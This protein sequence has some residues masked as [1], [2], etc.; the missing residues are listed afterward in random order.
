MWALMPGNTSLMVPGLKQTNLVSGFG[1]TGLWVSISHTC[2]KLKINSS[3]TKKHRTISQ[4]FKGWDLCIFPATGFVFS[5]GVIDTMA[6]H[7]T[8]I[9]PVPFVTL[10]ALGS[11]LWELNPWTDHFYFNILHQ[12]I[13]FL[14]LWFTPD[15]ISMSQVSK[16]T[17]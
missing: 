10:N 13:H 8:N 7:L 15:P 11:L 17:N 16:Y 6:A 5:C 14:W 4:T 2:R 9:S 1:W 12:N 3:K